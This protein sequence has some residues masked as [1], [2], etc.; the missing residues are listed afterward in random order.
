MSKWKRKGYFYYATVRW[1][2]PG[3]SLDYSIERSLGFFSYWGIKV[4]RGQAKLDAMANHIPAE[5]L[6]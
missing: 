4:F 6:K 3:Q 2:Y 5:Y 1:G